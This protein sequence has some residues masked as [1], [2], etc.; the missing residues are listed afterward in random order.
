MANASRRPDEMDLVRSA[1]DSTS[2]LGD[3]VQEWPCR[4]G[5]SEDQLAAVELT[6]CDHLALRHDPEAALSL[7]RN[8]DL[9]RLR[10]RDQPIPFDFSGPAR[11]NHAG[12]ALLSGRFSTLIVSIEYIER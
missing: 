7:G 3:E 11:P 4:W 10:N 2:L 6:E 1:P 8:V 9:P 5:R 12:T